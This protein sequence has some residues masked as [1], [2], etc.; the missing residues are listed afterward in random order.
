MYVKDY[1]TGLGILFDSFDFS[2][3]GKPI[4]ASGLPNTIKCVN[5]LGYNFASA[6][7]STENFYEVG[8]IVYNTSPSAGAYVGWV[9]VTRGFYASQFS[10]KGFGLIEQ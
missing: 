8:T 3:Y 9:C 1:V 4:A 5:C 6:K 10:F 2:E 7:P